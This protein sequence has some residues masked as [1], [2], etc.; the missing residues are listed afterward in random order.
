MMIYNNAQNLFLDVQF[1]RTI[2]F[3]RM[4]FG[5]KMDF[6]AKNAQEATFLFHKALTLAK[7][8]AATMPTY[9][10]ETASILKEL[11]GHVVFLRTCD[12]WRAPGKIW[13]RIV[14]KIFATVG[15]LINLSSQLNV[16]GYFSK[17]LGSA[18]II[19][20][21][22]NT[23]FCLSSACELKVSLA[24]RSESSKQIEEIVKKIRSLNE[25]K[26]P[27]TDKKFEAD[28]VSWREKYL[29]LVRKG[30]LA[31]LKR[32]AI[33]RNLI[34][35]VNNIAL[36]L[37]TVATL[38][39]GTSTFV[40]FFGVYA[41]SYSVYRCIFNTPVEA[42]IKVLDAEINKYEPAEVVVG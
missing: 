41:G 28:R 23:L 34:Y 42:E 14:G 1:S 31:E 26:P 18:P 3:Q 39:L 5:V 32:E 38:L 29:Q 22:I 12:S 9:L 6:A 16:F 13:V 24:E 8:I 11:S 40:L 17:A 10:Y 25:A 4:D 19:G 20:C 7:E 30:A 37:M 15:G 33:V 2:T 21:A 27:D 36:T 35:H